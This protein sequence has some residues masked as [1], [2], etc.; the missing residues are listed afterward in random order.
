MQSR[1]RQAQNAHRHTFKILSVAVLGGVLLA[2]AAPAQASEVVKLARL[3]ITG[4]RQPSRPPAP[5]PA[6]PERGTEASSPQSRSSDG[7]LHAQT[8]RRSTEGS[9]AVTMD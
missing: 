1:Q 2:P 3:L 6:V 7:E 8:T 5:Q 9:A 4:K